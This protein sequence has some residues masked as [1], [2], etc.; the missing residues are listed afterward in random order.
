MKAIIITEG[1]IKF[2][3]GHIA[4]CY[5]LYQA[6]KVRA[7]KSKI[8]INGDVS[9]KKILKDADYQIADWMK[10]KELFSQ[11]IKNIDISVVD[12]YYA[13]LDFYSEVSKQTAVPVYIDDNMRV[14][15]PQGILINGSIYAEELSFSKENDRVYLLGCQYAPLRKEFWEVADKIINKTVKEIMITSGGSDSCGMTIK[16]LEVLIKNYPNLVKKVVL[17][18]AFPDREKIK[19]IKDNRVIFIEQPDA[20]TMRQL[21]LEA[22]IAVSSGGQTIY[23]LA[24]VGTPAIGISIVDNQTANVKAWAKLGFLQAYTGSIKNSD[25]DAFLV[26]A[27]QNL[28]DFS[29][30]KV[31]S[32]IG[33][34]LVDGRGALRITDKILEYAKKET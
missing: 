5:S 18:R 23:E 32:G 20:I 33:R 11:L 27:V 34:K 9:I 12:S 21:M 24:R 1:G 4:R 22:D 8:L 7:I 6:F 14:D 15:Y 26:K 29:V 25:F 31:R 2:G 19:N 3:F 28:L 30:R 17:G 13:G 16:V 10:D